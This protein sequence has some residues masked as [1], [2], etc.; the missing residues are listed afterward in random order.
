MQ[1]LRNNITIS[2]LPDSPGC[3]LFDGDNDGKTYEFGEIEYYL[4]EQLQKPYLIDEVIAECNERF[5]QNINEKDV[6]EFFS[7]LAEWGLL[8]DTND[9]SGKSKMEFIEDREQSESLQ[10]QELQQPNRWH[11]FNPQKLLDFLNKRLYFINKLFWLTPLVFAFGIA[12]I[13]SDWHDFLTDISDAMNAFGM[14]GRLLLAAVTVNLISQLSRGTV[15]RRFHLPT[16]SLGLMLVFGLI[17]RFNVQ[18]IIENNLDRKTRLWLSAILPVVSV[19]VFTFSVVLWATS[20]ASGTFLSIIGAEIA[21]ISTI[22]FVVTTNPFMPVGANLFSTWLDVPN[23]RKR[24]LRAITGLF[25]Q[26]PDVIKKHS[27]KYRI[28]FALFGLTSFLFLICLI[29]FIGNLIFTILERR[30]QGAGVSLFL[31]LIVYVIWNIRKQKKQQLL[32]GR[33]S[34]K[35]MNNSKSAPLLTNSL[36]DKIKRDLNNWSRWKKHTPRIAIITATGVIML[37]PYQY[38]YGGEA[39]IFPIAKASVASETKGVIE[40]IFVNEGDWVE[41]G[42]KLGHVSYYHQLKDVAVTETEIKSKQF[43]I[44]QLLTTPSP[45]QIE[46]EK[47]E[48][49]LAELQLKYSSDDIKRLKPLYSRGIITEEDYENAKKEYDINNQSLEEA[50]LELDALLKQ[51]NPYQIEVLKADLERLKHEAKY[52]N[53]EL[54]NTYLIS[55]I[56]GQIVTRD[57]KFKQHSYIETGAVF[58]EIENNRTISLRINIPESDAGDI[59]LGAKVTLKLWAYPGKIFTGNV[60]GIEPAS[61]TEDSYGNIIQVSSLIDN[62]DGLLVSGFTGHAKINGEKTTVIVAYSRA[63]LRFFWVEVWSWIP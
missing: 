26:Q 14:I 41:A 21:I 52:Y 6:E 23:L 1:L 8:Q 42:E 49:A 18:V 5:A 31:F 22:S 51:V 48:I 28:A 34:Q 60:D 53:E 59:K 16:P 19:W 63:I 11:L 17:P 37:L 10:K 27:K 25:I 13:I 40:Q 61:S 44:Q 58:A 35:I 33:R 47:A 43:E 15:A 46:V 50:K 54:E 62:P 32:Q 3:K 55:P 7:L 36:K 38:E 4:L 29:G 24:S 30:F 20:R 56:Q 57:L 2:P 39:E 12:T 9:P 45:E